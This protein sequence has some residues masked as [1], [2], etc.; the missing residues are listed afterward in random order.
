MNDPTPLLISTYLDLCR[1]SNADI[2]KNDRVRGVHQLVLAHA[3]SVKSWDDVE[4]LYLE[5]ITEIIGAECPATLK[6]MILEIKAT[7]QERE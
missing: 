7:A 2:Y 6:N 4:T 1:G 5:A 3:A